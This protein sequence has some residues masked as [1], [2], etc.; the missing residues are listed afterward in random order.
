[1]ST[2]IST[3]VQ[4]IDWPALS[5]TSRQAA[6]L[7]A[8]LDG[9]AMT[10]RDLVKVKTPLGGSTTFTI[11]NNGN[12]E[13]VEEVIGLLVGVGKRGY[14]WPSEDPTEQRPAVVSNDLLVGYRV[15]DDLGTID[16]KALEKFRIGHGL[17]DW[18]AMSSSTEFG[19]GSGRNKAKRV[20]E[21]RILAI[22]RSGE[23][24]PLLLSVS[25]GSFD[26]WESFRKKLPS[27]HYECVIGVKANRAK[28]KAGQPYSQYSFR[29]HGVISEEH[30]EMAR[31]IY[32]ESLGKM[33]AAAPAGAVVAETHADGD[34]E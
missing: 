26:A 34:E 1:M 5:A 19:F 8:N 6:I 23:M 14:L 17:Y 25:G 18:A 16:P 2:A 13:T 31:R 28:N 4:T 12:L 24:W 33:F 9:E 20:K 32:T 15:S 11:D 10:E 21:H 30:G 22:L 3:N 7:K 29:A 27:F